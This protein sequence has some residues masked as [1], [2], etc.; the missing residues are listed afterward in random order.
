MSIFVQ[1]ASYRDP[2]LLP[3]IRD[4]IENARWPNDLRFGIAEQDETTQLSEFFDDKRFRID[5]IPYREAK[6]L[7]SAR[8]RIQ[9]LYEGESF[10]LQ[11]D[12]H[13]RF[14]P[15]WDE[16]LLKMIE[17][18][19]SAKPILGSYAG[20]YDPATN[21]KI[22]T[23]EPFKM[24]ADKFTEGGTILF[25]PHVIQGWEDLTKPVRSRFVSGHFFFTLGK[26]CG[27]YTYDPNLFFAGDEISLSAR[28]YTLGWDL[29][30]PHRLVLWHEYTRAGRTKI[31][32]DDP[33]WHEKD[34]ISKRRL[35]K[36]LR[37]E[38]NDSDLTGFDLGTVRTHA[39]YEAYAGIDFE[40]RTLSKCALR[41][42]DPPCVEIPGD[43]WFQSFHCHSRAHCAACRHDPEFRL[44]L[45]ASGQVSERDF[46]CPFS[47]DP[48]SPF[49]GPGTRLA[50]LLKRMGFDAHA[51]C[52]CNSMTLKMNLWGD[53]CAEH[54]DEILAAMK[55]AAAGPANPLRL[56]WSAWG[57]RRLV[58][59]A[60]K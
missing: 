46:G 58:L 34:A 31:W 23:T 36:L 37:E 30:H 15:N 1:V 41:G 49:D 43:P 33:A 20:I 9:K 52:L 12:S 2:E 24:V 47:M 13:H 45:V 7:C 4:C 51:G 59:R 25:M 60:L 50:R 55:S 28:S 16:Q 5:F 8:A 53:H 26:H 39:E 48:P 32:D 3:T 18:T 40:N 57:A 29:Y 56:P 22:S 35:R 21:E 19:G 14:A 27:E 17:Q 54:M 11:I 6:G 42:E 10:T 38:E 44:S